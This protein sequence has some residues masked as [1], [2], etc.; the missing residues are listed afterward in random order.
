MIVT[1][2]TVPDAIRTCK[3]F[4]VQTAVHVLVPAFD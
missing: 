4:V 1:D 3:M 2:G